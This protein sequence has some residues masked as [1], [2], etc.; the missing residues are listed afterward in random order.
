MSTD[1]STPASTSID[2]TPR[3]VVKSDPP[4]DTDA[5]V[6]GVGEAVLAGTHPYENWTHMAHCAATIYLIHTQPDRDLAHD[7]PGIIRHYNDCIGVANTATT[8][9]HETLTQFYLRAIRHLLADLPA[10]AGLADCVAALKNSPLAERDYVFRFYSR[11]VLFTPQARAQ[12][13]DPD[14]A[15]LTF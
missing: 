3:S 2:G 10:D 12:W 6:A 8:G 11:D 7:M 5:D 4:L 9:Y 13:V 14:V 1:N 15:P